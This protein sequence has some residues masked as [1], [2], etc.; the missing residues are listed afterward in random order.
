MPKVLVGVPTYNG[1]V[2]ARQALYLFAARR[3]NLI[4]DV[5]TRSLSLLAYCFNSLW[6][7]ALN[8]KTYD[9]FLLLHADIVPTAP[10]G[11]L[12]KLIQEATNARADLLS[13]VVPIKN[14]DGLTSTALQTEQHAIP[15]RL[16]LHEVMQLPATFAAADV[17]KQFGYP[18]DTA[19]QLLV[20][21]GCML[22]DL[23][24]N[25]DKWEQMYFRITDRIEKRNGKF[26]PLVDPEDWDFSRQAHA[27]GLKV[28]VTRAVTLLHNGSADYSSAGVWGN[29]EHDTLENIG[30]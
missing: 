1:Q 16:T 17:A 12:S 30:V 8:D 15:R 9:Y 20:N 3:D 4:T 22:M 2:D 13:A 6:C 21:T 25:R 26:V 19:Q 27:Q 7:E 23:R 18:D 28:A 5:R 11:W 24:R 10:I 14:Q 29:L